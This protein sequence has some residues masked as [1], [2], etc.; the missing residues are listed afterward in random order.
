MY[1]FSESNKSVSVASPAYSCFVCFLKLLWQAWHFPLQVYGAKAVLNLY[2]GILVGKVK[3]KLGILN[4]LFVLF[5][6]YIG[7]LTLARVPKPVN[8]GTCRLIVMLL[9]SLQYTLSAGF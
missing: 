5:K 4:V 8:I 6:L 7:C 9:K 1:E 2:F 3:A